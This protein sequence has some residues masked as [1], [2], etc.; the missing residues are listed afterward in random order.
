VSKGQTIG[1]V[2]AN[3]LGASIHASI[4]GH[5]RRITGEYIEIT[6]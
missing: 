4:N 5:A 1:R 3:E 2:E 6:A